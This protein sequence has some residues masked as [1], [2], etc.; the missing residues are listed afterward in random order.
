[1][2]IEPAGASEF[3]GDDRPGDSA[4]QYR[5]PTTGHVFSPVSS[6]RS[7]HYTRSVTKAPMASFPQLRQ[8]FRPGA[9]A[10]LS[11]LRPFGRIND[12]AG[13]GVSWTRPEDGVL[14]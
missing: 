6:N 12:L 5:N 14:R 4:S 9:A 1:M 3:P 11:F 7:L 13:I 8:R 2:N 10:G